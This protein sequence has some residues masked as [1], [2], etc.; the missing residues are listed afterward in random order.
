MTLWLKQSKDKATQITNNEIRG[1]QSRKLT[2]ASKTGSNIG[3]I[4]FAETLAIEE[5]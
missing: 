3:G 5:G 2:T 4:L 1:T